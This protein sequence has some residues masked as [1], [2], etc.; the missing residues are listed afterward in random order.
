MKKEELEVCMHY[1][2]VTFTVVE[3]AER[4]PLKVIRG[5]QKSPE[6][7]KISVIERPKRGLLGR[8]RQ[9]PP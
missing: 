3:R 9:G 6:P 5:L 8:D 2:R 1:K 4:S 7:E